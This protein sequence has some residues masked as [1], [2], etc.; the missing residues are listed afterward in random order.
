MVGMGDRHRRILRGERAGPPIGRAGEDV[1]A[2]GAGSRV[3]RVADIQVEAGPGMEV[4]L[5]EVLEQR[6]GPT[7]SRSR[8]LPVGRDT[9]GVARREDSH[10]VV[11]ALQG[12]PD[13]LEIVDPANPIGCLAG[14]LDRGQEPSR[15]QRGPSSPGSSLWYKRGESRG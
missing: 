11:V 5:F 15:A 1:E 13:L 7:P 6:R 3:R 4:V 14:G 9:K 10:A 12:Q 8:V 2:L